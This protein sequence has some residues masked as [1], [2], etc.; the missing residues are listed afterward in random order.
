MLISRK[1]YDREWNTITIKQEEKK[2]AKMV[3]RQKLLQWENYVDDKKHDL[4]K[5]NKKIFSLIKEIDE[6]KFEGRKRNYFNKIKLKY[7]IE[8][9]AEVA[10]LRNKLDDRENYNHDLDK[11]AKDYQYRLALRLRE[12]VVNLIKI[13]NQKAKEYGFANYPQMIFHSE[14]LDMES[15]I[16]QVNNYLY[17][18]IDKA[19]GLI[20]KY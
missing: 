5:M 10:S 16:K 17:S 18:R 14:E 12:D 3:G 4:N 11:N 2:L 20:N 19:N 1:N 13:R 15:T 6:N 7:L 9:D 8:N